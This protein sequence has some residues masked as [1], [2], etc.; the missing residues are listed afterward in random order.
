M[1]DFIKNFV[2]RNKPI[3]TIGIA[4]LL[5]FIA[6]I[7]FYRL[8]AHTETKLNKIG[9]E[10][11]F[12][13]VEEEKA[14]MQDVGQYS[15]TQPAVSIEQSIDEKVGILDIEFTSTGFKPKIA[16]AVQGQAVRWTNKTDKTIYLKQKTPTY[17]DLTQP[18][19]IEP[20]Q[21]FNYRLNQDGTWNYEEDLS[22]FFATI[23]VY[24]LVN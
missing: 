20:G 3:F 15:E 10:S 8:K 18:V 14:N 4:T 22:K 9:N 16:R 6:I 21:S 1:R 7:V 24:R 12:N 5:L 19:Q 11:T 2:E 17:T 23:N 13:V